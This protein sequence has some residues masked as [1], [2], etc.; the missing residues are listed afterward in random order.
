MTTTLGRGDAFC[1]VVG[2]DC[3]AVAI[4]AAA[5]APPM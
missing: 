4:T 3:D 1:G 5:K 2:A